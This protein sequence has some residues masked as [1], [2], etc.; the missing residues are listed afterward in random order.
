MR[1]WTAYMVLILALIAGAPKPVSAQNLFFEECFTGGI[2]VAGRT[3]LGVIDG[4]FRIHWD[5]SNTIKRAFLFTYRYG[6]PSDASF[7]LE[8]LNLEWNAS[9]QFGQSMPDGAFTQSFTVHIQDVSEDLTLNDDSIYVYMDGADII[10]GIPNQG[11]WSILCVILYE[12]PSATE[13]ICFR[14]Y[15]ASQPQTEAQQYEVSTPLFDG[16]KDVGFSIYSDRL[17]ST[18]ID[19]STIGINGELLGNIGGADATNPGGIFTLGGVRGHF[20]YENGELFGL[21]D[22]VPNNTVEDTDGIAVINEYFLDE[23]S[24]EFYFS[25]VNPNPDDRF[26]VHPAFFIAYSPDCNFLPD[27]SSMPRTYSLCR[28]DN[29][30]LQAAPGYDNYAWST[31]LGTS[32]VLNDTTLANPICSADTS[33]WYTVRMW[34]D[35]EEGCAQTIPVFV[36]V[37]IVP[38]PQNLE[39]SPSVCPPATGEIAVINPDGPGSFTY[40]IDGQVQSSPVFDNLAAGN[41]TIAVNSAQGCSWDSTV[42]VPLHPTH[43]AAFTPNPGSGFTPLEVFFNNSSTDATGYTWLIDGEE[44]SSS[45]NL[46]YTFPDSGSFEISLIA[47]LNE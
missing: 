13:N 14:A 38:V 46:L 44:V 39:V 33:R 32:Q 5:N 22:D 34:N 11:Y 6:N 7:E 35:D 29:L 12:S 31:T 20:Y 37:N 21:D 41:Y 43:E 17:G 16:S 8:G 2:T 40:F 1:H 9:S 23:P 4:Y 36:E 15:T 19:R 47:Y 25:P 27:L 10:N 28:G 30:A 26:N 42:T 18:S 24:Q 3:S 45:E